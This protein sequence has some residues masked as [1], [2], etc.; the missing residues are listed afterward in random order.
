MTGV[1]AP[2]PGERLKAERVRRGISADKVADGLHLDPWVIEALEADDYRRIGPAVYVRGHLKH[3]AAL[4]GLPPETVLSEVQT[5]PP[6]P[7]AEDTRSTVAVKVPGAARAGAR[8]PWRPVAALIG[9]AA[10]LVLVVWLKPLQRLGAARPPA[11]ERPTAS[12]GAPDGGQAAPVPAAPGTAPAGAVPAA[13]GS[14][15][16]VV[17]AAPPAGAVPAGAAPAPAPVPAAAARGRVQLRMSFSADSW[18]VVHD[19]GGRLLFS[20]VGRANSVKTLAGAAPLRVRLGYASGV[21][22]EVNEHAVA[23]GPQFLSGDVA[24]F[25]AGADGVLR[26]GGGRDDAAAHGIPTGGTAPAGATTRGASA[27]ARI[28][29]G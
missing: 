18:V 9:L 16:A 20:G 7:I 23:I 28:F 27:Q 3:Y 12:S 14:M 21:Q 26:R 29:R 8:L 2:S 5:P 19:A 24:A 22:L 25:D 15:P 1:A 10:L 17:H 13:V 11:V 6:A 4:L